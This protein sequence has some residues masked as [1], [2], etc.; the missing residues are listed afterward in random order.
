LTLAQQ[1]ELHSQRLTQKKPV[2]AHWELSPQQ[3][4]LQKLA[5]PRDQEMMPAHPPHWQRWRGQKP[6]VV[7][8]EWVVPSRRLA[9]P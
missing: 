7:K 2:F 5:K 6:L 9:R 3:E 1:R 4:L 8:L